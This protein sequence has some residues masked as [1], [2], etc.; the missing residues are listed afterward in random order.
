MA[1]AKTHPGKLN[2]GSVGIG[3]FHH[4]ATELF[5]AQTG[6]EM[7][8]V[9]FRGSAALETELR[10]GRIDIVFTSM[11]SMLPKIRDGSFRPLAITV[12][13]GS[14]FLPGVPPVSDS[15]PGYN[16]TSFFGLVT[17]ARTPRSVTERLTTEIHRVMDLPDVR[18][19]FLDQGVQPRPSTSEEMK[20]YVA[21]QIVD[22]KK[23]VAERKI[24]VQ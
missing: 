13:E 8:N 6:I 14:P 19:R 5:C 2:Y 15:V 24:E 22:W 18:Q 16:V 3:S 12:P 20:A 1:T 21:R 7:V 9:P 4:L 10:T 17:T 11:P 23:L